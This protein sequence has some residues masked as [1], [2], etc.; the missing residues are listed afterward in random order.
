MDVCDAA[1]WFVQHSDEKLSL[2]KLNDLCYYAYAWSCVLL[3]EPLFQDPGFL[4]E[5]GHFMCRKLFRFPETE[6]VEPGNEEEKLLVSVLNC[7]GE[8]EEEELSRLICS[9]YPWE[10]AAGRAKREEQ[11][12]IRALR[13]YYSIK[14]LQHHSQEKI[15]GRILQ[16]I[17]EEAFS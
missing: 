9:E 3:E 5:G 4:V 13:L 11:A 15:P 6:N 1:R 17:K 12:L 16:T 10:E 14:W 2:W 7:Y 8:F